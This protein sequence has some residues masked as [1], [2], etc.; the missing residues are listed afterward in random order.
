MKIIDEYQE[1]SRDLTGSGTLLYRN[2]F[3]SIYIEDKTVV[4]ST[5][6]ARAIMDTSHHNNVKIFTHIG[7]V[8]C[9]ITSLI[10]IPMD[11]IKT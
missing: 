8:D 7:I 6:R 2:Q 4:N 5:G 9:P 3:S 10:A 11:N 1:V